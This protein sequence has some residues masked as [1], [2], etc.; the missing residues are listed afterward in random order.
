VASA[1]TFLLVCEFSN[2]YSSNCFRC[3]KITVMCSDDIYDIYFMTI[4][5]TMFFTVFEPGTHDGHILMFTVPANGRNIFLRET[6]K[7]NMVK[8]F[9]N[10]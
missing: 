4:N 8:V 2:F 7:G 9:C 6:V 1:M 5:G 3:I 10:P